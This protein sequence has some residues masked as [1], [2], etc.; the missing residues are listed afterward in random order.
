M[1]TLAEVREAIRKAVEDKGRDFRYNPTGH[2]YCEYIPLL[3]APEG[4]PRR[5]TGCLVGA[6]LASLGVDLAGWGAS[7]RDEMEWH[8]TE[9]ASEDYEQV[10]DY[11]AV[12]QKWQDEGGTWGEAYDRAEERFRTGVTPPGKPSL[13]G[14]TVLAE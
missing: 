8:R 9:V 13:P 10:R 2:A 4:D 14:Q 1:I 3:N 12:A 7:I 5:T 6:A 11:L